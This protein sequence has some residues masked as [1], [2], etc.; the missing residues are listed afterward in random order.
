MHAQP[1]YCWCE[2]V[3]IEPESCMQKERNVLQKKQKL[4]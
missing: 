1:K 2:Y 3:Y 4:K